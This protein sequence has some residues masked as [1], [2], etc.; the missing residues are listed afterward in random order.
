MSPGEPE[1]YYPHGSVPWYPSRSRTE[2]VERLACSRV[3]HYPRKRFDGW[4]WGF[5]YG[6]IR[7]GMWADP[8]PPATLERCAEALGNNPD[9]SLMADIARHAQTLHATRKE[10]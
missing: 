9:Q 5:N 10:E 7:C 2:R 3:N 4:C 1:P 6:C 8:W